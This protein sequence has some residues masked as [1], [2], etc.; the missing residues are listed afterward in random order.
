[1]EM[2]GLPFLPFLSFCPFYPSPRCPPAGGGEAGT[3][4]ACVGSVSRRRH[5][6]FWSRARTNQGNPW[7]YS[8]PLL[9]MT[10]SLFFLKCSPQMRLLNGESR[11]SNA[12]APRAQRRRLLGQSGDD[13]GAKLDCARLHEV[14]VLKF[15]GWSTII[16]MVEKDA[17]KFW[18]HLP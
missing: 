2:G 7:L 15:G 10:P 1:M 11:R 16:Y 6:P 8:S 17:R 4:P 12:R 14:E 13:D 18:Q 9:V 5:V 3:G